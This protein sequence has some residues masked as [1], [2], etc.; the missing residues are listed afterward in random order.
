MASAGSARAF[1]LSTPVASK[2]CARSSCISP[3]HARG[4]DVDALTSTLLGCYFSGLQVRKMLKK[5]HQNAVWPSKR[6]VKRLHALASSAPSE[7][8]VA[9]HGTP[10]TNT[11]TNTD[12]WDEARKMLDASLDS[13]ATDRDMV[14]ALHET[15]RM[16]QVA[17]EKQ[18]SLT[19]GPWFTKAWLGIDHNA[20]IKSIAY[21]AAVHALIQAALDIARR[22]EGKNLAASSVMQQSLLRLCNPLEESIR[23]HL[24][25]RDPAAEAWLW[26]QHHPV[27]VTNL[28]SGLGKDPRLT[29]VAI[30]DSREASQ[31]PNKDFDITLFMLALSICASIMKLGPG[32]LS[33]SAFSLHLV[34]E[35]G[36]LMDALVQRASMDQVYHFTSSIGL[37]S[38]F[39]KHFGSRAALHKGDLNFNERERVFWIELVEKSLK[40]ALAREGVRSKLSSFAH[41]EVLE[42]NLAVFGFFSALGRRARSLLASRRIVLDDSILSLFRYLEGGCVIFYPRLAT[43]TT[44]Q[45][46]VEVASEEL[47]WIPFFEE[48]SRSFATIEKLSEKGDVEKLLRNEEEAEAVAAVLNVCSCWVD[49][50]MQYSIWV[51]QVQSAVATKFLSTIQSR[52]C[53]C[54][55]ATS[56]RY[57]QSDSNKILMTRAAMEVEQTLKRLLYEDL[58]YKDIGKKGKKFYQTWKW[59]GIGEEP[60]NAGDM[61]EDVDLV[62]LEEQLRAFDEDLQTVEE[63]LF[64][65]EGLLKDSELLKFQNGTIHLTAIKINLQKIRRLKQEAQALEVA[66]KHKASLK[67][68]QFPSQQ[69][70]LL[71]R[72]KKQESQFCNPPSCDAENFGDSTMDADDNFPQQRT[73]LCSAFEDAKIIAQDLAKKFTFTPSAAEEV[74]RSE[75]LSEDVDDAFQAAAAAALDEAAVS[76]E[77][78]QFEALQCELFELDFRIRECAGETTNENDGVR[79]L[80]QIDKTVVEKGK[81][82]DFLSK[83]TKK[84]KNASLDVLKGTQ[85]LVTDVA[86]AITLLKSSIS[87]HNLTEREKKILRRTCTDLASVIPIGFLMLLPVTAVGH[88]AMLAAIQKYVPALIPSAYAPERLDLLKQLE[89]LRKMDG[90]VA[91]DLNS[92]SAE[93]SG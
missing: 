58:T 26:Y 25:S 61:L 18:R 75:F 71:Q 55:V 48:N 30:L 50:F 76:K 1:G 45:L 49:D 9:C 21:Q 82:W 80:S 72:Y 62:Q 60:Q 83:S 11:N 35:T 81:V 92:P 84:F 7:K 29:A 41:L 73:R 63:V 17:I 64:K 40:G 89:Q 51:Q 91:R 54:I 27:A 3:G 90:Y 31:F 79:T 8:G 44:Y 77:I 14:Q 53:D 46:F 88:A 52:L 74:V 85:L 70:K 68:Q 16:F 28:T 42:H 12:I 56:C 19:K 69:S 4:R 36:L 59:G 65:L 43:L 5:Y 23:Q 22:R 6:R 87:G 39:L 33:C 67:E 13:M 86:V 66:L 57:R 2:S 34:E 24:L 93:D 20:W 37:K 15:A 38:E 32:K 47:V 78:A 10:I